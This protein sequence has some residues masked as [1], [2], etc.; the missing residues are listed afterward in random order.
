MQLLPLIQQK[1]LPFKEGKQNEQLLPDIAHLTNLLHYFNDKYWTKIGI[2]QQ[3]GV[4]DLTGLIT[5]MEAYHDSR[6]ANI[7][8]FHQVLDVVDKN[9]SLLVS[10]VL[11]FIMAVVVSFLLI[12]EL[13]ELR[14]SGK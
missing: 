2:L 9:D 7:C 1:P 10:G 12:K 6:W 8:F 14:T 3:T 5:R 13:Q 11:V 4:S